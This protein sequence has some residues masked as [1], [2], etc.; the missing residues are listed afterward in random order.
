MPKKKRRGVYIS[1]KPKGKK[2]GN[3]SNLWN[4]QNKKRN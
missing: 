3:E 2:K 4:S 1:R